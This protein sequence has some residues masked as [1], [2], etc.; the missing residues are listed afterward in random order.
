MTDFE[1]NKLLALAIGW[2]PNDICLY[3]NQIDVWFV[4]EWEADWKRFDYRDWATIGPI[5]EK[6]GMF[7]SPMSGGDYNKAKR[8]GYTDIEKWEVIYCD[9]S[10]GGI[11]NAKWCR[12]EDTCAKRAI[13]LAVIERNK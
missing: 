10:V 7:P 11:N 9:Y 5:A 8:Q 12:V 3:C 4:K 13:A 1:I 6:Y 2:K